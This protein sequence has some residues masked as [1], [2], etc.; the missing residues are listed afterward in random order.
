MSFK[1]AMPIK[2]CRALKYLPALVVCKLFFTGKIPRMGLGIEKIEW[3]GTIWDG[4][5]K[6]LVVGSCAMPPELFEILKFQAAI[7]HTR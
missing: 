6:S 4:T 3:Y 2:L 5:V 7:W 1:S